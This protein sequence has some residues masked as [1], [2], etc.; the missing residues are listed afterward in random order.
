MANYK[1]MYK[2]LFNE[3]TDTINRLE[4]IQ[5]KVEELYLE[6]PDTLVALAAGSASDS[7]GHKQETAWGEGETSNRLVSA[8]SKS[9]A[10]E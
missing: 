5:Q 9:S 10:L 4:Q 3:I 2:L 8:L 7:V 1:E 6:T